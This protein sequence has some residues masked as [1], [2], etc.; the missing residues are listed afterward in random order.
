MNK[1]YKYPV[2]PNK[3]QEELIKKTFR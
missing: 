2:Y 3:K 1:A